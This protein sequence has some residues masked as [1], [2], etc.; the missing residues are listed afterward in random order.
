[1]F[2]GQKTGGHFP[3]ETH[4]PGIGLNLAKVEKTARSP[5]GRLRQ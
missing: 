2:E 3:G 1:M 4:I 5:G